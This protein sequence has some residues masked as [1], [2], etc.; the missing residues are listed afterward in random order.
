VQRD[1]R[2]NMVSR[3]PLLDARTALYDLE[4][5]PDQRT[6]VKRPETEARI[7]QAIIRLLREHEA[8]AEVFVRYG[9]D[10]EALAT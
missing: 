9:L 6:P 7:R 5:D 8:P 4:V 1:A 2:A 10:A 3:Y